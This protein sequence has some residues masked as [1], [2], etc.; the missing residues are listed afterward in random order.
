MSEELAEFVKSVPERSENS[1]S[2]AE[3]QAAFVN[4]MNQLIR[5]VESGKM[6]GSLWNANIVP[7]DLV[8]Q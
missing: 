8:S 1:T 7:S 5:L 3:W 4:S 2:L 6:Q